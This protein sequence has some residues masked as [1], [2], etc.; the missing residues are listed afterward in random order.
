MPDPVVLGLAAAG[1]GP[2]AARGLLARG[3]ELVAVEDDNAVNVLAVVG[4]RG[5]LL[6]ELI[7][8][9]HDVYEPAV[10]AHTRTL[11]RELRDALGA[12]RWTCRGVPLWDTVVCDLVW[13][14][15]DP[16]FRQ[17]DASEKLLERVTP[18]RLVMAGGASPFRRALTTLAR[19]RG[20]AVD[21][22][23]AG[24]RMKRASALVTRL[25]PYAAHLRDWALKAAVR[26]GDLRRSRAPI[27]LLNHAWRNFQVVEPALREVSNRLSLDRVLVIQTTPDGDAP[28][29]ASGF[30]LREYRRYVPL[31]EGLRALAS[32]SAVIGYL[33]SGRWK[34]DVAA[35]RVAWRG[36]PL[37]ALAEAEI[38]VGLPRLIGNAMREAACAR[39][40]LAREA[41]AVVVTTED[42]STCV[43]SMASRARVLGI[44]TVMVQWGPI[45][46]NAAW[47][48]RVAT[49]VAAVEGEA[50]AE[51]LRGSEDG[52]ALRIV[53]TGQPKY[54][55]LLQEARGAWRDEVCARLGLD[56]S[57]PILLWAAHPIREHS[58][59]MRANRI[60]EARLTDEAV[61]IVRAVETIG[62]VQLI[63]KPHPNE[64]TSLHADLIQRSASSVMRHVDK[65]ESV[66]PLLFACDAVVTHRSAVGLEGVVVGKPVITVNF[67]GS[68][69]VLP[70]SASGV[71]FDAHS[72]AAVEPA[73]RTALLDEAARVR[74]AACRPAFI[75]RHVTLGPP[76]A[77]ARM[78]ELILR[79]SETHSAAAYAVSPAVH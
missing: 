56:P 24:R 4:G 36:I 67:A 21:D 37:E 47:L 29:I 66:Y 5:V 65:R 23:S 76:S 32:T 57:H 50:A 3:A 61:A 64:G 28:S 79:L 10:I 60:E 59:R 16:V 9:V 62:D 11:L 30:P 73:I 22:P 71:G 17:A 69:D 72:P 52:G 35:A 7:P 77:T 70:Y 53:V 33:T 74:M 43:R 51:V 44:P 39:V 58:A 27:V 15:L 63:V 49:D 19:T 41:P 34:R 78:T 75:R 26:R 20:L 2:D 68:P 13:T 6:S 31:V 54:D 48:P 25:T 40:M 55:R 45:A 42:R 12:D 46:P 14:L 1:C 38:S 8:G 18:S